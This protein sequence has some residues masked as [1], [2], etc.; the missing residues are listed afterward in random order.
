VR[1][2]HPAEGKRPSHSTAALF[3]CDALRCLPEIAPEDDAA[4]TLV[5]T[6][7]GLA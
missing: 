4:R 5:G 2:G 3:L 6:R 1:P 7:Q